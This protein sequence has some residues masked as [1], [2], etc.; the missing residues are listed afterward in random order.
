MEVVECRWTGSISPR[1]AKDAVRFLH[2]S[3][4]P[5]DLLA[6]ARTS[7]RPVALS[8]IHRKAFPLDP[9]SRPPR[10]LSRPFKVPSPM[11]VPP[12]RTRRKRAAPEL[13]T[14]RE[15]KGQPECS[16]RAGD[17]RPVPARPPLQ[18]TRLEFRAPPALHPA[19]PVP[20][21]PAQERVSRRCPCPT[22]FV[23][24]SRAARSLPLRRLGGVAG[25]YWRTCRVCCACRAR[26]TRG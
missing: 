4:P 12:S 23:P 3:A 16:V 11:Q 5:C 2:V 13:L 14:D 9:R 26:L 19:R 24:A 10:H 22:K 6:I 21:E 17:G 8:A 15:S 20:P 1:T 7:H 18:A 25:S